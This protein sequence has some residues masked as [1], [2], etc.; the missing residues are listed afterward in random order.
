MIPPPLQ[1]SICEDSFHKDVTFYRNLPKT[2]WQIYTDGSKTDKRVGAAFLILRNGEIW[3]DMKFRL[4]NT[5]SVFQAEMY[6]ISQAAA[7]FLEHYVDQV[8]E[9]QFYTDSMASLLALQSLEVTTT[10][11]RN[12]IKQLNRMAQVGFSIQLFWIKSHSGILYNDKVDSLAKEATKLQNMSLVPLPR[13]QVRNQVLDKLRV[14]W[15]QQWHSYTEARHS[16]LF[17]YASNKSKGKEICNLN[18]VDLRRF[19]MCL[20]NHNNLH[21]HQSLQDETINPTC[22]FCRMYDETFDHFFTCPFFSS[23]RRDLG[24]RWPYSPE[25]DWTVSSILEF[26]KTES[27]LQA[28]DRRNLTPIR[29]SEATSG[30]EMEISDSDSSLESVAD[31]SDIDDI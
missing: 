11:T 10:L 8:Q 28:V 4:P 26:I 5:A 31:V 25:D 23:I 21:Y 30:S 19:I 20:T 29:I 2:F 17:L 14:R 16:K 1:F 24:I 9:C 7:Y 22:R 27:I 18:R 6:A 12:A 13:S 15:E 3:S